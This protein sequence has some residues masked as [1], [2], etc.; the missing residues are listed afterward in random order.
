MSSLHKTIIVLHKI[1]QTNLILEIMLIKKNNNRRDGEQ[2]FNSYQMNDMLDC[3][4]NQQ[5]GF[6]QQFGVLREN[7][8]PAKKDTQQCGV[9]AQ[10]DNIHYP[11]NQP[12]CI[13]HFV[14]KEKHEGE[15]YNMQRHDFVQGYDNNKQNSNYKYTHEN[16]FTHAKDEY[17]VKNNHNN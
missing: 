8:Y 17:Y 6:K 13:H 14:R 3:N 11:R 7:I 10:H 1:F 12:T 9:H 15:Q 2:H 5:Y 4:N 16:D